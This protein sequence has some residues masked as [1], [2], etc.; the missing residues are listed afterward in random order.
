MPDQ[1]IQRTRATLP[2]GYQFGD[3][4][5]GARVMLLEADEF[6]IGTLPS[7]TT[8]HRKPGLW[9]TFAAEAIMSGESLSPVANKLV[10]D[11]YIEAH[12]NVIEGEEH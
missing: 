10:C 4:G 1:R 6:I 5:A 8:V 11:A 7:N 2:E 9:T 3:A 12:W